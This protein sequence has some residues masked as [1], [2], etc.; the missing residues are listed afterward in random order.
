V[1]VGFNGLD[2]A[3]KEWAASVDA[4][5]YKVFATGAIGSDAVGGCIVQTVKVGDKAI[6]DGEPCFVI[7][8]AGVNHNGSFELAKRLIDAAV[9]ADA[10]AVK[11]QTFRADAIATPEAPKAIYQKETTGDDP[12][13]SM[14]RALELTSEDF[15]G[16]Y[17]YANEVGIIFLSSPFDLASVDLLRELGVSAYKI[18]SGELTNR[19]LLFHVAEQKK[20][21]ILST[22]MCSLDEVRD[23]VRALR[24]HNVS[25]LILLHC[26][27]EYPARAEHANLRVIATLK[28]AFDVPVGF[29]DHTAGIVVPIAAA[30]V[31]ANVIEKHVTISRSLP[32]PDQHASLEPHEL[33]QMV[34]SIRIVEKA[35]GDG[36]KCPTRGEVRMKV[37]VRQTLVAE[38]EI[39]QGTVIQK[40][41]L[42]S[43]RTGDALGITPA[44]LDR[45]IGK[46]ATQKIKKGKAVTW[47]M[48]E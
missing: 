1:R 28:R 48:V 4:C 17:H 33:Q 21:I 43:K 10:D 20:P 11:F 35:L 36:T 19:P 12:Q 9:K 42:T 24:S 16:L 34:Q 18:G 47:Q 3:I 31:G 15:K 32:G 25:D 7:A 45:F 46:K 13:L 29:S 40:E 6:G 26:V 22:G 37:F 8:E 27:S 30:A 5:H 14:L 44:D 41:M 39:A 38:T 23:A 2:H